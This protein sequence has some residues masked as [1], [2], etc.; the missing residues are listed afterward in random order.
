MTA[1]TF[2]PSN[3][4][5][6]VV[7]SNG[8]LTADATGGQHWV[9]ATVARNSSESM[10]RTWEMTVLLRLGTM[11]DPTFGLTK[12]GADVTTFM[13]LDA[14][15]VAFDSG[16]ATFSANTVWYGGS[17]HGSWDSSGSGFGGTVFSMGFV[18]RQAA[19]E[20]DVYRDGVLKYT[21]TGI[22]GAWFPAFGTGGSG[23]L[24][25]HHDQVTANFA[26]AP[27]T[28]A[29]PVG[30]HPYDYEV[31]LAPVAN[32]TRTPA[33]GALP[34][35]VAFTDT[36]T[37]TPTSWAWTF[38]D[39]ATST[40]QN[41]THVY[42][43]GGEYTAT[44]T[45]TNTGGSDTKTL[46]SA[47]Y[48]GTQ[49][50]ALSDALILNASAILRLGLNHHAIVSP[51]TRR[52]ITSTVGT[53]LTSTA[54][55]AMTSE[56]WAL[57]NLSSK[58]WTVTADGYLRRFSIADPPVAIDSLNIGAAT[59]RWLTAAGNFIIAPGQ[60]GIVSVN[61]SLAVVDEVDGLSGIVL[62][63]GQAGYVYGFDGRGVGHVV[64]VNTS[65][66]ALS[67]GGTFYAQDCQGPL[68][69]YIVGS[70]LVVGVLA[71]SAVIIFDLTDPQSPTRTSR[72][73][74]DGDLMRSV[75]DDNS[76]TALTD[77][78]P[79]AYDLPMWRVPSVGTAAGNLT[80]IAFGRSA[81]LSFSA[82]AIPEA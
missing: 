36:S 31:P 46:V 43:Q 76:H 35:S 23:S 53:T 70:S 39:G 54:S 71:R 4:G 3:K 73:T 58:L 11:N 62:A 21:R 42:A 81:H 44:L 80:A 69:G 59:N 57:V 67:Y 74:N 10:V 55:D 17:S 1:T 30:S 18:W 29:A 16:V 79:S 78:P 45:A 34:L 22:T 2:N 77:S 6:S 9:V 37:N 51:D 25:D 56:P 40:S 52:I 38:G 68:N 72:A 26:S 65:T 8:N 64:A 24:N 13:G 15:A 27:T 60:S 75:L 82:L 41:P 28:F 19:G 61:T 33:S 32:F 7:L 50:A 48:A 20:V 47:V 12:A 66:G 5:S 14:L 49:Q 63:V